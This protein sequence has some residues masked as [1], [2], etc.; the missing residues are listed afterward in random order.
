MD[1]VQAFCWGERYRISRSSYICR[2]ST[3][4]TASVIEYRISIFVESHPYHHQ[5]DGVS[6]AMYLRE[7]VRV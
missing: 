7:Q 5:C 2:E 4:V 1:D 3:A 6:N